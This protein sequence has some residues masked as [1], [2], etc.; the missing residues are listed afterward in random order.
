MNLYKYHTDAKNLHRHDD[1]D[2][3]IASVVMDKYHNDT[4]ELKLR[5]SAL[6]KDPFLAYHYATAILKNRFEA[7][8]NAI[9]TDPEFSLNYAENILKAPFPKGEKTI[10]SNAYASVFYAIDV[11]DGPFPIGEKAIARSHILYK[12]YIDAFPERSEAISSLQKKLK[13][14][15]I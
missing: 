14:E 4:A 15:F 9:A 7:G 3:H 11:L 12:T 10:A 8:E 13:Y 5:E 2:K 6:A 1:A